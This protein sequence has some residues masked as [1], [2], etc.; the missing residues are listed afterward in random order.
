M[1][2]GCKPEW[3]RDISLGPW[4][5]CTVEGCEWCQC[6]WAQVPKCYPHALEELGLDEIRKRY[7]ETHYCTWQEAER[8]ELIEELEDMELPND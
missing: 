7:D 3:F 1:K 8:Q 5:F 6:T 2:Y 4:E